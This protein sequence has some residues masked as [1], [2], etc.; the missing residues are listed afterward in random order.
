MLKN[1]RIVAVAA[2]LALSLSACSS[3]NGN[4]TNTSKGTNEAAPQSSNDAS[5]QGTTKAEKVKLNYWTEDR[6][7]L[8]YIQEVVDRFNETNTDNIEVELKGLSENYN[9]SVDIAF[10]SKQAPDII[11]TTPSNFIPFVK[12]GYLE[13]LDG[14]LN[15]E[16]KTK[17]QPAL[18]DKSNMM[19]GQIYSLPN[20]GYSSR[21]IYNVDLFEKAGITSPPTTLND[22]VEVAKKLTEAGKDIGAYGFAINFKGADNSFEKAPRSIA[23]LSGLGGY[24]Y[25]FKTGKYDFS[26][27]TD[28]MKAF[29]Q[30][31]DDGSMLP[32]V[33]ALDID[34]LRAQ[35]AEGKIGMYLSISAEPY[36]YQTQFPTKVNWSAALPPTINGNIAGV[37]G[38]WKT[39]PWLSISSQTKNKKEAWTFLEYMYSD[40]VLKTYYEDGYGMSLLPE[41][42]AQSKNP[43]MP[44]VAGF[45]P[46]QYDGLW[47]ISPSVTVEG[48]SFS[49][50]FIKYVISGGD[51]DKMIS[52][53]NTR[54][55]A[56]LDKARASGDVT[57][58]AMPDFDAKSMQGMLVK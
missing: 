30:M 12:K 3:G 39:G 31:K 46:T 14:Y 24:G 18:V 37:A 40:E 38:Y 25:D 22:M 57:T 19:N 43:E 47:P 45:L 23:E 6:H 17:F 50:L 15:D 58:E 41:I 35:F 52:D 5:A 49:N 10:S 28:I 13:P 11:R 54:Y 48:T 55:N 42:V 20:Y 56:A 7:D 44:G 21:L 2:V 29:K 32:G 8:T 1:T 16:M 33:E 4:S 36:V 9:Q 51:L 26:G 53:A 27:F 34:P